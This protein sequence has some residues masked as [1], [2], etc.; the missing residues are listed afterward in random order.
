MYTMSVLDKIEFT[1]EKYLKKKTINIRK[2]DGKMYDFF[3]IYLL[4]EAVMSGLL[5]KITNQKVF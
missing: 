4:R 1:T 2:I 5:N 3:H